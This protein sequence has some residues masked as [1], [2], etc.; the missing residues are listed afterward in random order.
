MAQPD[1][2]FAKF[3]LLLNGAVPLAFIAADA[4]NGNLGANP[5]EFVLRSTGTL[6]LVF[7]TL[8]LA[9]TPVR[10]LF[11]LP[12][13]NKFRRMLGLYTFFYVCL[14]LSTYLWLDQSFDV[15]A[16]A[17]D[18]LTR[19]FITA[20]MIGFG[21]MVP[22]A[23]TST[24]KAQKRLGPARWNQIHKRIYI[25]AVAAVVHYWLE[26]K[27]DITRPLVFGIV[28]GLLLLYRFVMRQPRTLAA[29]R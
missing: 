28:L 5:V 21:L 9:V 12:W 8:T 4:V 25:V 10:K 29:S 6:T 20:G 1:V 18:A 14:H 22:M 11:G 27:A 16:I 23:W 2:K 26:V 7:L 15:R 24:N 19:P 17:T 13:L 3:L